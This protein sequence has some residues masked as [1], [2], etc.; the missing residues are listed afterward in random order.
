MRRKSYA[1]PSART[2]SCCCQGHR[3]PLSG[4]RRASHRVVPAALPAAVCI[5]A[6]ELLNDVSGRV[7]S[8]KEGSLRRTLKAHR[9]GVYGLVV[10]LEGDRLYSCGSDNTIQVRSQPAAFCAVRPSCIL[11]PSVRTALSAKKSLL[12]TNYAYSDIRY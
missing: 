1:W 10:S 3:T 11:K 7:W 4:A 6:L 5:S 12:P 9:G 2:R 8:V